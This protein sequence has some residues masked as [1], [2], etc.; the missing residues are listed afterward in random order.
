[1][2]Q[3]IEKLKDATRQRGQ[4]LGFRANLAAKAPA[5]MLV[6]RLPGDNVSPTT[7]L[8]G[9]D[10]VLLELK[11]LSNTAQLKAA[12]QRFGSTPLGALVKKVNKQEAA[13]LAEV[14]CDFMVFPLTGTPVT[15]LK[16]KVMG[17]IMVIPAAL[18]VSLAAAINELPV[19]AVL[20]Q[21]EE[22]HF[23]TVQSLMSIQR[24]TEILEVPALANLPPESG[25][26]ELET[27][28]LAGVS[29]VVLSLDP[30]QAEAKIDEL[31]QAIKALP[32]ERKKPPTRRTA[33]LPST[34]VEER[35][36]LEEEP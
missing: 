15:V 33:L 32:A 16:E 23:L 28:K 30:R 18:E 34:S 11:G 21:S 13:Q 19:D 35:L 27:L 10:A 9:I 17:R 5:M 8:T 36:P 7:A 24:L 6:A 22:E 1:M 14:G 3:L 31:R 25:G 2:S 29:G 4:P 12:A 26:E 20:I